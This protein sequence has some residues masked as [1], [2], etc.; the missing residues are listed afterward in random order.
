MGGGCG[1]DPISRE[2]FKPISDEVGIIIKIKTLMVITVLIM[3]NLNDKRL[4]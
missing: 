4:S 3:F 1:D 2:A